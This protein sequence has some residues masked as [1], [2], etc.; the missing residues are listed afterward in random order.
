MVR[1]LSLTA[2][3]DA[4]K[5]ADIRRYADYADAV[6]IRLDLCQ[7]KDADAVRSLCRAASVPVILHPGGLSEDAAH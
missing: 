5:L 6:E 1:C 4:D 2:E 7:F 3:R